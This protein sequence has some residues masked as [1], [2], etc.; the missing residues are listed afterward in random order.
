[1]EYEILGVLVTGFV[2]LLL[3]RHQ[4]KSMVR[5]SSASDG[6]LTD[7]ELAALIEEEKARMDE[8]ESDG[9]R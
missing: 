2:L 1:M 6:S 4:F 7:D 5:D 9:H 3:F 8:E